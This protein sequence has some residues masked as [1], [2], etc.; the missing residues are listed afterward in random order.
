MKPISIEFSCFGPYMER[1][2]VDFTELEKNGIF[3]I[4]GETGAG[5]T[6]IL[7]AISMALYG[8]S[9]GGIR[10]ELVDMR[11]KLAGKGDETKVEFIFENGN[12][13]YKFMRSLR[14]A[15]TNLNEEHQ[16]M[17]MVDG[18]WRP[19]LANAKKTAVNAKAEEII[20][21]TY[22]QFRQVIILPQGQFEK[23]LTSPSKDKEVI[24]TQ[25]FHAG[26]WGLAAD[27][28]SEQAKA[29]DVALKGELNLIEAK[30]AGFDCKNTD[31]LLQKAE[32]CAARLEELAESE[33]AAKADE[34]KKKEL[35]RQAILDDKDFRDLGEKERK[36]ESLMARES[37]V[38]EEERI[39]GLAGE[40][41][42]LRPVYERHTQAQEKVRKVHADV[43]A[44]QD[45]LRTAGENARIAQERRQAHEQSRPAC[46]TLKSRK[47]T[48]EN[49][50]EVYARLGELEK[51]LKDRSSDLEKAKKISGQAAARFDVAERKW[52]EALLGQRDSEERHGHAVTVYM[53]GISGELAQKLQPG[54]PCPVCGS[55]EHPA[56]AEV[57]EDHITEAQLE[58]LDQKVQRAR[59]AAK[60]ALDVRSHAER[61]RNEAVERENEAKQAYAGAQ[62]SYQ[63]AV[64]Q[65]IEGIHTAPDLEKEIKAAARSIDAF[66][67]EEASTLNALQEAQTTLE[68]AKANADRMKVS[69]E[70]AK[71]EQKEADLAWL[72]A[73]EASP[74]SDEAQ[75]KSVMMDPKKRQDRQA[76]CIRFRTELRNANQNV[77]EKRAALEGK[78]AP[79]MDAINAGVRA[80]EETSKNL[81]KQMALAQ[82]DLEDMRLAY[83]DLDARKR[84]YDEARIAVDS[85]LEFADMLK[86]KSGVSLQ[87]Y[88]L[89]VR[90]AAVTAE[91]NRLLE[92]VY[93]GR[94]R[95][96]RTDESSGSARIKGLE[97]D[98]YDTTQNQRRS[99]NTLSGGEKFLVALS[100]AI[101]LSSVV[102]ASG[103]G[104]HMEAMFV[105]EGFGSLDANAITDA[106][107]ILQGIRRNSGAVVGV[108]SHVD[109]LKETISTRLE[110][111]KTVNGS[112]IKIRR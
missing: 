67:R 77:R 13:R 64:K 58:A 104:V 72:S 112:T 39:L 25:L 85:D 92:T 71:A 54:E 100:L 14:V 52:Q 49:A 46:E 12:R 60:K 42:S 33:R 41:E 16:C 7:D 109:S 22:D 82:K 90:F 40:A 34:E 68:V 48:L 73:L 43:A 10:G 47:V 105:D 66:E 24:L 69:L 102:M 35:Q 88:V 1:Q 80:A 111:E 84:K 107:T 31:E 45:K 59:E 11:C 53:Q 30:L 74:L 9:S 70:E 78:S 95:L 76:A 91:A 98:V 87:R 37:A 99:V 20:G 19:L 21:L 18:E 50:R 81:Q 44:A 55:L 103:G 93:G 3:L 61:E 89:G 36:R 15:R 101:G 94:Y 108:I 2:F 97:L 65:R 26:R 79:D 23:L 17:E 6:T 63:D 106:V 56:P 27:K 75:Y 96:Y 8:K 86:P 62:A 4:C 51:N 83:E 32:A 29:R 38:E 110:V 28:V 5:K 57:S